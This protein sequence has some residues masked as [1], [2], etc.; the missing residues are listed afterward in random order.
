MEF[1]GI[2]GLKLIEWTNHIG[3][4]ESVSGHF[5]SVRDSPGWL[6]TRQERNLL[7]INPKLKK[8]PLLKDFQILA[9]DTVNG[10][11]L[12]LQ[13]GNI[14]VLCIFP[15]LPAWRIGHLARRNYFW[16]AEPTLRDDLIILQETSTPVA[17]N[18]LTTGITRKELN[19]RTGWNRTDWNVLIPAPPHLCHRSRN[20]IVDHVVHS[21]VPG[22]N[23]VT[24][25]P[26][27]KHC[28]AR[29]PITGSSISINGESRISPKSSDGT[30][31]CWRTRIG[32]SM[33]AHLNQTACC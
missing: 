26:V 8:H 18:G 32:R 21:N 23:G 10:T 22:V 17:V 28:F 16:N 2:C 25:D 3:H 29:R 15:S 33:L 27:R 6:W 7:I 19:W 12:F 1:N 13:I 31:H 11:Y 5:G 4:P 14:K 9:R 24:S 30:N 20:S